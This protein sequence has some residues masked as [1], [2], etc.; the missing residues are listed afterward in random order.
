MRKERKHYTGEEKVAILRRHLLDQFPTNRISGTNRHQYEPRL[1][2]GIRPPSCDSVTG[3]FRRL[4]MHRMPFKEPDLSLQ[5]PSPTHFSPVIWIS[6]VVAGVCLWMKF[7]T[8]GWFMIPGV[9]MYPGLCIVHFLV[10]YRSRGNLSGRRM[11]LMAMSHL[12]FISGFLLQWDEG[13]GPEWL[14]LTALLGH[15]QA[16]RWWPIPA[17]FRFMDS[18]HAPPWLTDRWVYVVMVLLNL[19]VFVPAFLTYIPMLRIRG[20][21]S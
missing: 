11:V 7:R 2:G 15:R 16:P 17:F 8:A 20:S 1:W 4:G 3:V 5:D 13:D 9:V 19:V 18:G 6:L 21:P 12:L 10:H 14:T